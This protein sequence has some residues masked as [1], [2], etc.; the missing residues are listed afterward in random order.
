[1]MSTKPTKRKG[2]SLLELTVSTA[3][4]SMIVTAAV[5]S[6]RTSQGIWHAYDGDSAKIQAVHATA[7]SLVRELRQCVSVSDISGPADTLGTITAVRSNSEEIVWSLV[8]DDI[9]FG[10]LGSSENALGEGLTSM[11]FVG[12]EADGLTTTIT[13][14]DIRSVEVVISTELDR[15]VNPTRTIRTRVWLR[16]W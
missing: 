2:V 15:Q 4:I 16:S 1:M 13:P 5:G 14:S 6:I 3:I 8:G 9:L 7:L 10:L 12:Y 11:T